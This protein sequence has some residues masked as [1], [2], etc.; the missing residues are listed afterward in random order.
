MLRI[1]KER[2]IRDA[3]NKMEPQEG[4]PD[5]VLLAYCNFVGDAYLWAGQLMESPTSTPSQIEVF[6]HER[7]ILLRRHSRVHARMQSMQNKSAERKHRK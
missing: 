4:E 7:E 1:E 6:G 5:S 2:A 3:L